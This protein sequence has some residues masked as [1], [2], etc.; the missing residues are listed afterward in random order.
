MN[1]K[2][3]LN[4]IFTILSP[5][6]DDKI[7]L[8]KIYRFLLD[9]IDEE[10]QELEIPEKYKSL[11]TEVVDCIGAGM[12]CYINTDT[13]EMECV[14]Q[15]LIDDPFEFENMTGETIESMGLK[16]DEWENC[17]TIEALES[18]ESF[19]IME[20]FVEQVPDQNFRQILIDALNRRKPFANFKDIIDDSAY[21]QDWFDF[22]QAWLEKYV[23]S[24][25]EDAIGKREKTD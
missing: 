11:I 14:S 7:K 5:I 1:T 18:R 25:L 23:F 9:E 2:E 4:K 15:A 8:N 17:F 12:V 22:R 20:A 6:K 16:N 13:L 3:L 10:P 21:R 19:K 24:L